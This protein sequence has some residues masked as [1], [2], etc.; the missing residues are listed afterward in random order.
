MD[1]SAHFFRTACVFEASLIVVALLLGWIAD[2]NPFALLYFSEPALAIGIIGTAPLV[3]LFLAMEYLPQKSLVD[4]KDLLLRTLAP[5][6]Q[7][8]HWTDLLLLATIAGVSEEL[9]FRGVI[10][11]WI[12]ASWGFMAG[13]TISNIIFGLVHAVTPLYA[14]LVTVVGIYLS[15]SMDMGNGDSNLLIPVVI[16]SLYDF[17]AF[18]MLMR[19]YRT[20][21]E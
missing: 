4:I 5:S 3:L 14:V 16:H 17:F 21:Q 12:T 15:V 11:P 20:S 18:I 13:L 8:R 7:Q 1:N 6:L 10:Q 19:L 9:L 2:I